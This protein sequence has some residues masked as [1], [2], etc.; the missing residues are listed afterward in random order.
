MFT[1]APARAQ[2]PV[3]T[4]AAT[5][6]TPA[7]LAGTPYVDG[8]SDQ[9]LP[10]W[11]GGFAGSYFGR[12]FSAVWV[13]GGHIRLARY[14]AQWDLMREPSSGAD[15]QG[16]YRERLEAWLENVA[17][18]G[19]VPDLA[20]T[21]Y[22][23]IYPQSAGEYEASLQQLLERARVMGRPLSYVEA[24]NEPNNQGALPAAR[25]AELTNAAQALCERGYGCR[26]VAGNL[27]DSPEV[28]GYEHEYENALDFSPAIWGVHP[29]YSVEQ[30][31]E[32]P[33]E[34]FQ[35]NLP[36]GGAGAQLWFTE[37]AARAC[38][39]YGGRLVENGA[40]GQAERAAWLVDTLMR[41]RRPVHVFYNVFLLADHRRSSCFSE[42]EDD[43]LY[44]PGA[45]PGGSAAGPDVPRAAAGYIWD[46]RAG[47]P[48]GV[49]SEPVAF[50]ARPT[51]GPRAIAWPAPEEAAQPLLTV[52]TDGCGAPA[53]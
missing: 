27:E 38:T 2:T 29:Y 41:N 24:W 43:A 11:D 18:L 4:T 45:A 35:V 40:G 14:V 23:G 5:V 28:A 9:S 50:E 21:S 51:S 44:L 37:I 17:S 8:I 12:L 22:D 39:D 49:C 7:A 3:A 15:A 19:L 53:P 42:S 52:L 31:S 48:P 36:H 16:D 25:A 32:A 13:H 30:R 26:V 6:A 47:E 20:L 33:F 10:A 1:G 46:R 34:N